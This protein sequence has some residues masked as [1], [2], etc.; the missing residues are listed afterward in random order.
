MAVGG[1]AALLLDNTVPGTREERGLA[2]WERLTEDDA[3]FE[4]VWERWLGT[5]DDRS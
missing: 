3:E 1:L 2:Q 4:T 5:D